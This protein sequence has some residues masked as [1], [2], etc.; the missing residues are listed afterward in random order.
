MNHHVIIQNKLKWSLSNNSINLNYDPC[1][2][3][4]QKGKKMSSNQIKK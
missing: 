2:M 1:H 3:T 4:P